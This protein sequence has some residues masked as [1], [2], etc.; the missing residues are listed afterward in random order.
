MEMED[1]DFQVVRKN[2]NILSVLILMLAFTNAQ[3]DNLNFL[4]IEMQLDSTKFY[5]AIFVAYLYFF[6]RFL[7]KVPIRGGFWSD[8]LQYYLN[9]DEG[10]KK[11]HNY[12]R[13]KAAL[14]EKSELLRDAIESND[15]SFRH[16]Q[17]NVYRLPGLPLHKLRFSFS[18]N[19]AHRNSGTQGHQ[20]SVDLDIT[21]SRLIAFRKLVTFCIKYDKFGDYIFPLIPTAIVIIF[22]FFK[23]GWQG[24]FK[25]LFID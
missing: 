8:F 7:T 14:Q 25:S 9:F 24:S 3:L 11:Q 19:A 21:V 18:F 12:P 23:T 22:F 16:I 15:Q 10:I 13:Y 20:F 4:G 1:H 5:Q 6:W 2:L 17:T